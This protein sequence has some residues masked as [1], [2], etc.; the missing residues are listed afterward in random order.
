MSEAMCSPEMVNDICASTELELSDPDMWQEWC[1]NN[2]DG[3]GAGIMRYAERWAKCMQYAMEVEGY[4]LEEVAKQLSHDVDDEYI[5]G[6]MYG[7]AV[8]TLA[9]CW[10]YGEQLRIWHNGDYG[11][12]SDAEGV[13]NPAIMG[14]S[15]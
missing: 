11:V 7:A 2:Q 8:Q 14:V 6:F 1:S 5:T 15:M 13:V 4:A 9:S 3:Y 12:S 10:Q